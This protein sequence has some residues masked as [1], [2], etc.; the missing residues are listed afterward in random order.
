MEAWVGLM[1]ASFAIPPIAVAQQFEAP[2]TTHLVARLGSL[3]PLAGAAQVVTTAAPPEAR[4]AVGTK[5]RRQGLGRRLASAVR[6]ILTSAG[7]TAP[8]ATSVID[9]DER[10]RRFAE[11]YGFAVI[12][13]SRGFR[14]DLHAA[15][16]RSHPDSRLAITSLPDRPSEAEWEAAYQTFAV[17]C[18]DTPDLHGKLP[19]FEEWRRF[20]LPFPSASVLGTLDGHRAAC[21]FAVPEVKLSGGSS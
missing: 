20:L 18:A 11:R 1:A 2:G 3:G 17:C 8:L 15:P 12:E 16:P 13:H 21:S 5:W 10:S 19:S 4:V 7:P 14:L 6:D 9:N